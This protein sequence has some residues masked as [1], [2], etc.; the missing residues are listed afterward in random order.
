MTSQLKKSLHATIAGSS[1]A[2]P[3]DPFSTGD[4]LSRDPLTVQE[5]ADENANS[6]NESVHDRLPEKK[7]A[8]KKVNIFAYILTI[9]ISVAL[10]AGAYFIVV[11]HNIQKSEIGVL[12]EG[13]SSTAAELSS[14]I[15]S[16]KS[17]LSEA[18][19]KVQANSQQADN[20]V[21]M[22]EMMSEIQSAITDIRSDVDNIRVSVNANSEAINDSQL[23]I[24]ALT[25]EIKKLKARPKPKKTVTTTK[26][27]PKPEKINQNEIGGSSIG[28]IDTW[29]AETYVM[30][31]NSDGSWNP[32]AVG[33]TLHGWRLTSVQDIEAVF[34]KGSKTR[35]LTVQ[36]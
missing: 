9:A 17:Q 35:R 30:M 22:K 14:Q 13:L 11:A 34:V 6:A 36:E 16:I 12:S 1:G 18:I 27:V 2:T 8:K 32:I 15:D 26:Q 4:K 25:S 7:T 5:S 10:V 33:D 24:T 3:L 23:E 28:S 21:S 29:G 19:S 20:I 31:R